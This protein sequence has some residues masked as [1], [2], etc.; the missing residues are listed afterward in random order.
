[1]SDSN[2]DDPSFGQ[3]LCTALQIA[4]ADLLSSW[5]VV[6][7]AVI[8]HSSGEIAAACVLAPGK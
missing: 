6:P 1:M 2:V 8:G 3:P 4:L 7:A 5:Y